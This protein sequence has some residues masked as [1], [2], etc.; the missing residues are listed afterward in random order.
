[1]QAIE[2]LTHIK[3]LLDAGVKELFDVGEFL[4]GLHTCLTYYP[5]RSLD[6]RENPGPRTLEWWP[7]TRN[8][9]MICTMSETTSHTTILPTLVVFALIALAAKYLLARRIA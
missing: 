3:Q 4:D 8:R 9:D 1:M 5:R 7:G 6:R 2:E